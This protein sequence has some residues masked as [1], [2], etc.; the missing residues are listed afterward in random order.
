[1]TL[2]E[3]L[4]KRCKGGWYTLSHWVEFHL[5]QRV[6]ATL[7]LKPGFLVRVYGRASDRPVRPPREL[8]PTFGV[9]PVSDATA[10]KHG[11]RF[12]VIE[13]VL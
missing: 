12:R 9:R 13:T 3:L 5:G 8:A 2:R 10:K 4:D 11:A 6:I 7:H 1:M